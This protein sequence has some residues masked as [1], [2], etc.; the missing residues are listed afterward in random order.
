MKAISLGIKNLDVFIA[1]LRDGSINLLYGPPGCGKSIF[2]MQYLSHGARRGEDVLYISLDQPGYRVKRDFEDFD[3]LLDD[4]YIFDA[5]PRISGTAEIKPVREVTPIAKPV[6]MK[7]LKRSTKGLEADVLSLQ[8]TLKNVFDRRRYDRVVVDS[9]TSL[10][11]FYMRG[12]NPVGG[13]HSFLQFLVTHSKSTV[14]VIAEDFD[15]LHV[16][17]SVVDSVFHLMKT[18]NSNTVMNLLIEK[19]TFNAPLENVPLTLTKSGFT[20]EEK[21]YLKFIRRR[22]E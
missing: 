14:I 19:A 5:Y 3:L 17:K 9:I 18:K 20:V 21:F 10:K 2:G 8:A 1:G 7:N 22:K 12:L 11:Y 6:K 4:I 16:E 15:D 13:V